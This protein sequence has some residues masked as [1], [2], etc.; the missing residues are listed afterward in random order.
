MAMS[1]RPAPK[2]PS[3]EDSVSRMRDYDEEL[4][5]R[6]IEAVRKLGRWLDEMQGERARHPDQGGK[7]SPQHDPF[8][9]G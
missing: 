9:W 3:T 8:Y 1:T 7:R 2:G 6:C 5:E 4:R